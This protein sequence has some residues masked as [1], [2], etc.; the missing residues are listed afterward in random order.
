VLDWWP[1]VRRARLEEQAS[2]HRQH[3][4]EL[5]LRIET[6]RMER[7]QLTARLKMRTEI[8]NDLPPLGPA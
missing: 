4:A 7:D 3:V 2:R 5:Q 8:V 1:W 6:L